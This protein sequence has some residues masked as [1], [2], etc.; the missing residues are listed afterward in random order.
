M[1]LTR[2]CA[3]NEAIAGCRSPTTESGRACI[4]LLTQGACLRK[5]PVVAPMTDASRYEGSKCGA[6]AETD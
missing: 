6:S 5:L 2:F 3:M 1:G 4:K